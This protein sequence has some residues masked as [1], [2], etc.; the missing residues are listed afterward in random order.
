MVTGTPSAEKIVA[1]STPTAPPPTMSS[2]RGLCVMSV[3]VSESKTL[4]SPKGTVAG[5]SGLEPVAMMTRAAP[6]RIC[7]PSRERTTTV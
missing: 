2:S 3:M 5:R 4:G 6:S 7:L 1:Y